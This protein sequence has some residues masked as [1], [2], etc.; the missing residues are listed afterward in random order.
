[1]FAGQTVIPTLVTKTFLEIT[2]LI[3]IVRFRVLRKTKHSEKVT[4]WRWE[5]KNWHSRKLFSR[6]KGQIETSVGPGGEIHFRIV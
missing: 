1:M 6:D 3:Q 4:V 5:A 2:P